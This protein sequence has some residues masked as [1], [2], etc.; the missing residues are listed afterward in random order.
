MKNLVI[1]FIFI[2]ALISCTSTSSNKISATDLARYIYRHERQIADK[3]NPSINDRTRDNDAC[4]ELERECV[5]H[6][7]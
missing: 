4:D 7:G 1:S 3:G 2:F 6:S 5:C